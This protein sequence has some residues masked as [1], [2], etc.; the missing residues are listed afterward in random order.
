MPFQHPLFD[1]KDRKIGTKANNS[2]AMLISSYPCHI[3][4][5][6]DIRL[7]SARVV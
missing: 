3:L 6:V 1:N 7:D 4:Y 5:E 2:D